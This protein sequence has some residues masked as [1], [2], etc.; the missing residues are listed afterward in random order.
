MIFVLS[1]QSY[2]ITPLSLRS[3][4]DKN[5]NNNNGNQN[6]KKPVIKP[7]NFSQ[8]IPPFGKGNNNNRDNNN[9]NNDDDCVF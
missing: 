3:S 7:I 8:N 6:K 9:D 5:T 1:L 2:V 4:N